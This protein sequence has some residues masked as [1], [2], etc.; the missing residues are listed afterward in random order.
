M[1]F[2][3]LGYVCD[4]WV[5]LYTFSMVGYILD[6]LGY[7][8]VYVGACIYINIWMHTFWDIQLETD[9]YKRVCT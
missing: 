5:H 3:V 7:V 1:C 4:V 9:K 2:D 6:T 8:S